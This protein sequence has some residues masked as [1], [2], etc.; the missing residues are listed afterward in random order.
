MEKIYIIALHLAYGG[1]EKA[2]INMANIFVEKTDVE[3]IS[4]Y[5]MPN[6]PAFPLDERVRVTYLLKDIPNK[7]EWIRAKN[8]RNIFSFM[9]ESL[10]AVKILYNKKKAVKKAI[11][12]ISKGTIITTR[13][14]DTVVLSK[15]GQSGVKKI[16]QLHHD[17][18]FEPKLVNDIKQNYSNIDTLVLLTPQ[19]VSETKDMLVGNNNHTKV[20]CIPN[21]IEEIPPIQDFNRKK[22][23][24]IS[25]GRLHTVKAFDR[26]VRI[27]AEA[28]KDF[29][30]WKLYIVGDGE[31]KD[32]LSN[33]ISDLKMNDH[34]ILT[35]Q[36]NSEEIEELLNESS[37]FAMTSLSEGLP[38]VLIEA[39][40]CGVPMIAYD[41]RVG[42]RAVIED[43]V[44][45][46][47][48]ED[49][50]Q[51][52]YIELLDKMMSDTELR[53]TMGKN[54][55]KTANRF[56]KEYVSEMWFQNL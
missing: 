38:F 20:I 18:N 40:S 9:K 23:M 4:V 6:A 45:G 46:Y 16:A 14:E 10:K 7:E 26:L 53:K 31:E 11:K 25:V 41:V 32:N 5:K 19:L 21:F 42:P 39:C 43:K 33:L 3:I 28:N 30:D 50:N 22:N 29:P 36:K 15:Y 1:V 47:L 37:I 54:A 8:S 2:I 52:S 24:V 34:I 35:G 56:S 17:H 49:N 44:N 55:Y 48:V 27:F 12:G 13:N 51:K